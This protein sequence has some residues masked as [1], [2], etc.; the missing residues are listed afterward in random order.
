MNANPFAHPAEP[1]LVSICVVTYRSAEVVKACV[2]SCLA[3]T[4]P[5]VEVIVADDCSTDATLA[6]LESFGNRIQVVPRT[7]NGGCGATRNSAM[8]LARGEF[9]AWM[10]A[11]DICH[12]ERI[13]VEVAALRA[14]PSAVLASAEFSAFTDPARDF[15]PRHARTYYRALRRA[16]GLETLY[17]EAFELPV[18][19]HATARGVPARCGDI[20]EKMFDGNFIHPP[21]I[22]ARRSAHE[23][24]GPF[25]ESW[26]YNHD[27]C[28]SLRLLRLGP[29]IY[30]DVPLLRYRV[31]PGQLSATAGARLPLE[32][33][34]LLEQV[35]RDDPAATSRNA[36]LLRRRFAE[37]YMDL[38]ET[39]VDREPRAGLAAWGR[40]MRH[41]T[42]D[43][44]KWRLLAK[45]LLPSPLV[46]SIR[47]RR[48][49]T[50]NAART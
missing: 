18:P 31:S 48:E 36:S 21:T 16:G 25:D 23:A 6:A 46:A 3:Q 45:A 37:L 11:D 1:G 9:I 19:E 34:R 44:R 29:A 27:Y 4:Y 47:R 5:R 39:L 43:A 12:P 41:S 26:R 20:Y 24:A 2:E 14:R 33:L 15:D 50:R 17:P 42:R 35:R 49:A 40:A 7:R 13:A 28:M 22:L 38:A 10:D 8:R 32:T 30:L